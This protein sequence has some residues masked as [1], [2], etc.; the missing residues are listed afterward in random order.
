[1]G[2]PCD[3]LGLRKYINIGIWLG[4]L[5]ERD[6]FGDLVSYGRVTFKW[7]LKIEDGRARIELIGLGSRIGGCLL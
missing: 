3:T 1:M 4:K 7:I 6:N 2:G 5:K